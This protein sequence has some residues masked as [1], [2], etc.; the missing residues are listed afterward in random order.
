MSTERVRGNEKDEKPA[1]AC[2][3]RGDL[4]ARSLATAATLLA[5]LLAVGCS[6]KS[7][8]ELASDHME[9]CGGY[10]PGPEACPAKPEKDEACIYE[11]ILDASCEEIRDPMSSAYSCIVGCLPARPSAE[12]PPEL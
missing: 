4:R 3:G 5:L 11:C 9:E 7:Q 10:T 6:G 2:D 8:C 1:A 12:P